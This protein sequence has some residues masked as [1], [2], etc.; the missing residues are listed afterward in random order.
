MKLGPWLLLII[1]LVQACGPK[2]DLPEG[3]PS[4]LKDKELWETI[5]E[6]RL[7]F[8]NLEVK[9]SGRYTEKD[10]AS[11]S[12]RF[13]LRMAKDSLIWIDIADPILGL[14]IIRA[15]IDADQV[16][17]FNRLERSYFEGSSAQLAAQEGFRFDFEPLMAILSAN[18]LD[19]DQLWRQNYVEQYYELN[20]FPREGDT[21]PVGELSL[22][23]Q[24]IG[25]QDFRPRGLELK[26]PTQGELLQVRYEDYKDFDQLLFPESIRLRLVNKT[27]NQIELD[28]KS[29]EKN[30][31]LSYPFRIPSNYEAL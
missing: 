1:L 2:K 5:Q 23:K 31:V 28:I 14:K 4:Y 24:A 27:D 9:G 18:V 19:W 8:N 17:Y 15:Q 7:T 22:I 20:N 29:V 26:R 13:T 10:G 21:M 3:A 11:L 16:S 6:N 25:P 30:Q 12:F